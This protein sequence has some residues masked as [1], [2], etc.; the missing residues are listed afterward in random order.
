MF[1]VKASFSGS[2]NISYHSFCQ[3]R[4]TSHFE[5][6]ILSYEKIYVRNFPLFRNYRTSERNKNVDVSLEFF[7]TEG[8]VPGKDLKIDITKN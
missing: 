7:G 5:Q 2:S 4:V 8:H 3:T 6:K 1:H